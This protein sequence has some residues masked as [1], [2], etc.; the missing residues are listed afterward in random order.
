MFSMVCTPKEDLSNKLKV[1]KQK[2]K[3]QVVK[4]VINK[5]SMQFFSTQIRRDKQEEISIYYFSLV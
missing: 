1:N 4:D 5:Y 3:K 2:T